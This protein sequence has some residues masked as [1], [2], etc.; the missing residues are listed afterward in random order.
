MR[1]RSMKNWNSQLFKTQVVNIN[2]D[3]LYSFNNVNLSYGILEEELR[4]ILDRMAPMINVQLKN[5]FK[6]WVN[7][8]LKRSISARDALREKAIKS[9]HP[10]DWF[11][12][13]QSRNKCNIKIRSVRENFLR[14]QYK[15]LETERNILSMYKTTCQLLGWTTS[16]TP[17]SFIMNG[18]RIC[19]PKLL[20]NIQMQIEKLP[21]SGA[22]PLKFLKIA[23]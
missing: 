19:S 3:T 20:A 23:L 18:N 10:A 1:K 15:K 16:S 7:A 2:W 21:I 13:K 12:Y 8:E 22:D 9:K 14:E 5:N 11:E 4:Q 17:Q 6:P